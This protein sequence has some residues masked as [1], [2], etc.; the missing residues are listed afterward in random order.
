M[1]LHVIQWSG[2]LGSWATA[3]RVA[4]R[5]GIEDLV[6]LFANVG[7][8]DDDLARWNADAAA[9]LGVPITE[10]RDGRTPWQLF[11]DVRFIGNSRVA[12]C[13]FDLKVVPCRRWLEAH[14]SPEQA[15]V[16]IGIDAFE[17][18]RIPAIVAGWR[19]WSVRFPMTDRPHLTK[20]QML[21]W[22]TDLGLRSPRL[23]LPP[24]NLTHNDC[25]GFC[26]RAG[27]TQWARMLEL[28][29]AG[30]LEYERQEEEL[31]AVLGNVAVLRTRAG[32]VSR[33]LPLAE[34]RRRVRQSGGDPAALRRRGVSPAAR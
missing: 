24:Y 1:T 5:H 32:G 7:A 12:R 31:R 17:P 33:P 8:E 23:Y 4:A 34:L 30:Y 14:T 29:P 6:L 21:K 9:Q 26:V 18:G 11:R 22:A 20:T 2:G 25:G 28:N 16:Y 10:V 3:Q 27:M 15:I 13:S 19:P